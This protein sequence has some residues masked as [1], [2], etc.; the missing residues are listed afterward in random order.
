MAHTLI[1]FA[2]AAVFHAP[3]FALNAD[4]VLNA[5]EP[6]IPRLQQHK[7]S[8]MHICIYIY[9]QT[10]AHPDAHAHKAR[11]CTHKHTPTNRDMCKDWYTY[12]CR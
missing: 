5:C 2:T 7:W 3:M 8:V 9:T 11:A 10:H 4:A 1:M 12:G 6:T